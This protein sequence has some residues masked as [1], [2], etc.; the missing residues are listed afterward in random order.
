MIHL[1]HI[2]KTYFLGQTKIDALKQVDFSIQPKSFLALAGSS[3]SGKSTLLNLVGGIER[4]TTGTVEW[5]GTDLYSLNHNGLAD[6]RLNKLGFIFQTFNL[7]PVL[8]A[9][10]NVEYP[11]H[12]KG[13]DEQTRKERVLDLLNQVGLGKFAH[14]RPAQLSGGQRQRVAIARALANSP[15]L[16]LADEPTA[17]LDHTTGLEIISLLKELNRSLGLTVVFATHDPKVIRQAERVVELSDGA[18]V[19]DSACR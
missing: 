16:L 11:L 15:T 6:W 18:I 8:T 12:L 10:E 1:Q 5:E 17:N 19:K 7:L 4:P 14:H 9:W 3:G 2:T 13:V